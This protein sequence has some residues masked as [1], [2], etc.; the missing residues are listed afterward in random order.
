MC[1]LHN[2][3]VVFPIFFYK[4]FLIN[5]PKESNVKNPMDHSQ[6]GSMEFHKH[7][8]DLSDLQ[9]FKRQKWNTLRKKKTGHGVS[10]NYLFT[11]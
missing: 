8:L 9:A 5:R 7:K 2:F 1:L 4:T 3:K 6:F 10:L 11:F